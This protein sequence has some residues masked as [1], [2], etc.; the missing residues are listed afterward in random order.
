LSSA[1]AVIGRGRGLGGVLRGLR[2]LDAELAVIVATAEYVT[3]GGSPQP[4]GP[5]RPEITELRQ[6]LQA[7]SDDEV[8]LARALRRPLTIERLGRHPIGNLVIQS[9][10]SAFGD[11]G[12]ASA[13]L[14]GQLGISGS[15]LP[16]TLDNLTFTVE[17]GLPAPGEPAPRWSQAL[18]RVVFTP[19]RPR[20][21][22]TVIR[23]ISQARVALLAPG[24]LFRSVLVAAAVPDITRM[25]AATRARII[26][27]CNLRPEGGETANDQFEVLRRHRIRVD[28]VLHDPAAALRLDPEPLAAQGVQVIPRPLCGATPGVHDGKLLRA[29]VS[30]LLASAATS[31]S[32]A[33]H[34]G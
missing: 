12:T 3:S 20:V 34:R 26:W 22:V 11:L 28:A 27:I 21:T 25:L 31:T 32:D 4:A 6:S 29:A 5:G 16:T 1:L 33:S 7:L 13:W 14:G 19:E 10:A 24:S 23:A 15:V 30:E 18:D 2:E 8:A 9:L 17:T